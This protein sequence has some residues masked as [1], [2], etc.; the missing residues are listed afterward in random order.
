[1]KW[2]ERRIYMRNNMNFKEFIYK[3]SSY[4]EEAVEDYE[5]V[6]STLVKKNNGV[7]YT[8]LIIRDKDSN[9]APTVYL[10][11][12]Y[13]EDITEED[14]EI[15]GNKIIKIS[16][17]NRTEKDFDLTKLNDYKKAKE[18]LFVKL[19][20]KKAND[21]LLQGVPNRDFL[22]LS[23]IVYCDVTKECEVRG[24]FLV[25]NALLKQWGI[26]ENQLIC[27]AQE[28]TRKI[29][30]PVVINLYEYLKTFSEIND[31]LLEPGNE[32]YVLTNEETMYG[33]IAM[34]YTDYLDGLCDTLNSS[35]LIIPSSI[36]EG[37]TRFAA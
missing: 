10:E 34:T 23:V 36:H 33:A 8:G 31:D 5:E 29:K 20:N 13:N 27:D 3:V 14:I 15:I 28:N 22:D 21:E 25:T 26:D 32:M 16:R 6:S 18:R 24:S 19:I 35:L 4:I 37:A 11:N 2:K 12:F 9:I 30:K 17:E 1:M 7:N